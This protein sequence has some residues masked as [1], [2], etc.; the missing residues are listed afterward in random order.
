MKMNPCKACVCVE[1]KCLY[2]FSP[3]LENN[4]VKPSHYQHSTGYWPWL[5]THCRTHL[6]ETDITMRLMKFKLSE[7]INFHIRII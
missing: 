3:G 5:G 6:Y 1:S 7:V 4:G 2:Y